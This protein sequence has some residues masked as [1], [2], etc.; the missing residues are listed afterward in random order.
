MGG[1]GAG[2][3]IGSKGSFPAAGRVREELMLVAGGDGKIGIMSW[4]M[5]KAGGQI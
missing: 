5:D 2:F 4:N 3:G 1:K